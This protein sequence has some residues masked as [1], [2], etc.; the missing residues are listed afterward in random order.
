MRLV[1]LWQPS[2]LGMSTDSWLRSRLQQ[3]PRLKRK[4]GEWQRQR[5]QTRSGW[6]L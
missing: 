2:R 6:Q 4:N 5:K 1:A 3:R